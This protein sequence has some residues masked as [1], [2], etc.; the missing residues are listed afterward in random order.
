MANDAMMDMDDDIAV[1][2]VI[3]PGDVRI[4]P[5]EANDMLVMEWRRHG[6]TP[7]R[8]SAI[9]QWLAAK[10]QRDPETIPYA[11]VVEFQTLVQTKVDDVDAKIKKKHSP[12]A[13]SQPPIQESLATTSDGPTTSNEDG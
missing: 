8:Q 4:D 11:K 1:W 3:A 5:Y 10:L 9:R 13:S 7:E 2:I 12:T 6:D